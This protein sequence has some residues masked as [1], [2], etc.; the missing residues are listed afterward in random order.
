MFSNDENSGVFTFLV[1]MIV[2]VMAGV[3]LSLVVDRRFK[4]SSGASQIRR[5][6]VSQTS[7]LDELTRRADERGH[8]LAASGTRLHAATRGHREASSQL[9][10]LRQRQTEL[11]A[12]RSQL[13]TSV[14]ALE[15]DFS[16]YRTDYRR[17]T[18]SAA[19]GES[20]GTLTVRG[21]RQYLQASITRVTDVGLEIRHEHGIARVQ[22]PD[23]DRTVQDRFQW[24]DEQRRNR[25]KEEAERLEDKAVKNVVGNSDPTDPTDPTDPAELNRLRRQVTAWKSKVATVR[26]EWSDATSRASN[27]RQSSVPGSLETWAAKSERLGRDLARAQAAFAAAKADLSILAPGDPLLRPD[28]RDRP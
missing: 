19:V 6:I 13:Q 1:G 12:N 25:L 27:G 10:T 5:D 2:L 26:S 14:A 7:E 4:F 24:D 21:G 11:E 17:R 16:D 9:E 15:S 23:L 22:A 20:L 28:E 3:G 8:Q 18:W